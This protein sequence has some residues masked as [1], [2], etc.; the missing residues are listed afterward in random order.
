MNGGAASG[1]AGP[2]LQPNPWG[3]PEP[4][5]R[6]VTPCTRLEVGTA[7]IDENLQLVQTGG[8]GSLTGFGLR[9]PFLATPVF[10]P[11]NGDS[12]P[13]TTPGHSGRDRRYLFMLSSYMVGPGQHIRLRGIRQLVSIGAFANPAAANNATSRVVELNQTTPQ[14][15]FPDGNVTWG[16]RWLASRQFPG[17]NATNAGVATV[18]GGRPS[19]AGPLDTSNFSYRFSNGPALLYDINVGSNVAASQTTFPAAHTNPVTGKPD[20]YV[21]TNNYFPP[22]RGHFFGEGLTPGLAEWYSLRYPY[23][24]SSA[25]HSLDDGIDIVGPG[26]ICGMCSV[27]QTNP[28]TRP[29]IPLPGGTGFVAGA[30]GVPIEEAFP[31]NFPSA[32]YWR[33]G[34]TLLIED[35]GCP[36]GKR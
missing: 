13:D 6:Q 28:V 2:C 4:P 11:V 8:V 17:A 34:M 12:T 22:N 31:I 24:D 20:F 3:P 15:M 1:V 10:Q 5:R 32:M 21:Y 16:V 9:V 18:N 30:N 23:N 35:Y 36:D 14:F 27:R 25:W 7:G 19:G 29:T 33:V 26:L